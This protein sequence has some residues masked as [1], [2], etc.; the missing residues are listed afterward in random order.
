M[1]DPD[2][3]GHPGAHEHP[4]PGARAEPSAERLDA[5]SPLGFTGE[6]VTPDDPEW[7]WCFQAHL[8]GYHDLAARIP[9]GQAV[10]DIGCGEGYGANVLSAR[11]GIVVGC[12]VS[13]ETVEHAR[14]RYRAPNIRW[15]VCDA[16]RL[17]FR[18]EAFDVVSSLQV[19]EHLTDTDAHLAGVAR[20]LKPG[21]LH[22][23]T[24]PNI[25]R[26]GEAERDNPF[27]LRDFAA[28]EFRRALAT[29][30]ARVEV[31]GMFYVE[32]SPRYAR[33]KAAEAKEERLRPRLR[34]AEA[35][36][37]RL[38]GPARVRLRPLLRRAIGVP[39]WPLPEA[40]AARNAIRAEDFQARAPAEESFCLVGIA[41]KRG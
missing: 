15:L 31:L 28:D 34:K 4:R 3:R 35:F 30:F 23:V 9:P 26:M 18:G 25:D 7:A 6:R 2:P 5:V 16:Q 21:G 38:P 20:V 37:A 12:D 39:R 22:Y 13:L 10:L 24:T 36:L 11:S 27:H 40:D 17:P 8:F 33:L 29:H 1:K 32:S 19:I 41:R 14:D